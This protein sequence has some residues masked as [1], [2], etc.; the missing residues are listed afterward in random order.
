MCL[1]TR[2]YSGGNFIK[3]DNLGCIKLIIKDYNMHTLYCNSTKK[4]LE[5]MLST[6]HSLKP[7][8]SS[9]KSFLK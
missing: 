3:G 7:L 9:N 4:E 6:D 5:R 2:G 1:Y 8:L